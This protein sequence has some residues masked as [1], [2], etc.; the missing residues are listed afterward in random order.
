M[1]LVASRI[2]SQISIPGVLF[3]SLHSI[4]M[5]A[6]E[7]LVFKILRILWLESSGSIHCQKPSSVLFRV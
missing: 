5:P 2:H 6:I 3:H 7:S 4:E 1:G